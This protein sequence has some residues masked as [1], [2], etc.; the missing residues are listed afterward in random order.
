MTASQDLAIELAAMRRLHL[1]ATRLIEDSSFH[2]LLGEILDAALDVVGGVKGTIQLFD[3]QCFAL[4]LVVQRGFDDDFV[5]EFQLVK[6][7]E[8]TCGT[9]MREGRRVVVEDA[10]TNPLFEQYRKLVIAAG[11]K[12]VQST[13][14]VSR[15]G[16]LL[17]MLSTY[18]DDPAAPT[19]CELRVLDLLARQAADF[20]ERTRSIEAVKAAASRTVR[21]QQ[22]TT[23]LADAVTPQDAARAIGREASDALGAA[24]AVVWLLTGDG[25]RLE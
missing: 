10:T 25:R 2:A 21:L 13:P 14:L 20:I 8:G 15:E 23:V 11:F 18:F 19:D 1:V 6:G 17:G 9:A 3:S 7:G 24:A 5:R 4:R 16:E 12:G 22:L